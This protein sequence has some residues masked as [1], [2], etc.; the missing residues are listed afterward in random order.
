MPPKLVILESPYGGDVARNKLYLQYCIRD[1]ITRGES[2][3]ASHQMLTEA[4]RDTIAEERE[5]GIQAGFAWHQH[6]AYGVVYED[7]GISSG[8]ARGIEHLTSLNKHVEHRTLGGVWAVWA[9]LYRP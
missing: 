6:C 3:Y 1:C 9:K 5:Q 8:M 4:L 2:P 7:F